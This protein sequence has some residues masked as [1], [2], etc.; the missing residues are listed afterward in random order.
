MPPPY[1]LAGTWAADAGRRHDAS[2]SGG[3]SLVREV[4][5]TL[6]EDERVCEPSTSSRTR[7]LTTK[8]RSG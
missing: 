1:S 4:D 7:T 2:G 8:R 6:I 5:P 3:G